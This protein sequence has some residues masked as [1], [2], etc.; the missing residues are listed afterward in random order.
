MRKQN[1]NNFVK[2]FNN[3][4]KKTED[5]SDSY[6]KFNPSIEVRN[7]DVNKA[8]RVLKKR[9]ERADFQKELAKQGYY[10][11][12]SVK[13]KRKKDQARKRW[14][15]YLRDAQLRGDHAQYQPTGLKW[16]KDKRKK[17]KFAD[18]KA[19]EKRLRRARGLV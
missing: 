13:R 9:L 12:P 14:E 4:N 2:K 17:R 6:D 1:N 5:R 8:I 16:M 11:K 10:E 19:L 15:R 7:G 18:S 3:N